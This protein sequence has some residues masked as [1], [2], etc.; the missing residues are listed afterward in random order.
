MFNGGNINFRRIQ[1]FLNL[2][3]INLFQAKNKIIGLLKILPVCKRMY[4][5]DKVFANSKVRLN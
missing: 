2:C 3:K 4:C 5:W 1:T